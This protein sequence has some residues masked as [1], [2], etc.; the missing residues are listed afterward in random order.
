MDVYIGKHFF[1]YMR[2]WAQMWKW[3]EA[4]HNSSWKLQTHLHSMFIKQL[5]VCFQLDY[6]WRKRGWLRRRQFKKKNA[7]TKKNTTATALSNPQN[8]DFFALQYLNLVLWRYWLHFFLYFTWPFHKIQFE[9]TSQGKYRGNP[10]FHNVWKL[11]KMYHEFEIEILSLVQRNRKLYVYWDFAQN[12]PVKI[13]LE[14]IEN[15]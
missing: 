14:E 7:C 8:A 3:Q 15:L 11:S 2:S 1:F 4:S 9:R 12:Q 6:W 10:H 13:R 5:S